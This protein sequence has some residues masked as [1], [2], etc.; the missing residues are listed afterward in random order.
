MSSTLTRAIAGATAFATCNLAAAHPGHAHDAVAGLLHPL[1]GADHLLAMLA[2]GV[3]ACQ[4]GGR[5]R[6]LLPASFVA[7]MALAG[8]AGMAGIALPMVEGGIAA[9][10]LALGLLI[11]FSV[12]LPA[13]AGAGLAALFA[14]CHGYAHGA[15][16]PAAGAAWQYALGFLLSTAVLHGCG[17]LLG[18]SLRRRA[19]WLRGAGL[20]LAAGGAWMMAVA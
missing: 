14:I 16:M 6:W 1:L 17:L 12:R 4:L 15:E 11:A 13:G 20:A 9:S 7:L 8:A 18:A 3:W 19:A 10:L 5:A 2:V